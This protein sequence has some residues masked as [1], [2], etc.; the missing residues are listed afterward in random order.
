VFEPAFGNAYSAT[1]NRS[2]DASHCPRAVLHADDH[3]PRQ[4]GENRLEQDR[5]AREI[6][7]D[8]SGDIAASA[9]SD[10]RHRVGAVLRYQWAEVCARCGEV[11]ADD[12]RFSAGNDDEVVRSRLLRRF[13]GEHHFAA[14]RGDQMVDRDVL[15]LRHVSRA[16]RDAGWS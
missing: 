13:T 11:A 15:G 6:T 4:G 7:A 5:V 3:E 16:D 14:S 2:D 10:A 12:M 8:E 9:V 1:L